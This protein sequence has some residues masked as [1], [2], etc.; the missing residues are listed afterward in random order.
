MQ[1]FGNV[2]LLS[3]FGLAAI[4]LG[5][6]TAN[7]ANYPLEI[8]NIKP[9]GTGGMSADS[10]IY[11]AYP[12]L[13]Y[14]I[15]AAA[16]GGA[17]PYTYSLTGAPAGMTINAQTGE[18]NWASPTGTAN[19][20]LAVV[21][22]EGTRVTAAWSIATS[23]SG[24]KFVDAVNGRT[25]AQNGCSSSCGTGDI[26]SPWRT[27]SDVYRSPSSVG[28]VIYFKSGTYR[29]LD[30][31][32]DDIN[33]AWE[34]VDF[35][36]ATTS[37]MWVAYPGQAPIIDLAYNPSGE[38][39]PFIRLSA[40]NAYIDGFEVVNSHVMAFQHPSG[41]P[42]PTF[43]RNR[44]HHQNSGGGDLNGSNAAAI[45]TTRGDTS[46]TVIQ[47]NE[48]WDSSED[49]IKVYM[50]RKLLIE[51]NVFRDQAKGIEL[52]DS[53]QQFTVRGNTFSNISLMAIGGNMAMDSYT[54]TGEMLFNNVRSP[55]ALD[56]NQNGMAGQIFIYRNTFVGRTQVR[57]TGS[58]NGPF[59]FR[60]NVIVSDDSGTPS[61]SHI[62]HSAV[63]A[64][65]VIT[66]LNNL[67]GF[68]N[69]NI[70]DATG[71][72]TSAYASYRPTHGHGTM[73]PTPPPAGAPT[74]PSGVRIISG[75]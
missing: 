18:I 51:N 54:T 57:N 60:N 35:R 72:L 32:R 7:A 6:Q 26:A 22:S 30:L 73:S 44:F 74:A 11:H 64:P 75:N 17:Y 12:G 10:R 69:N 15:R 68:P 43:R 47:D 3:A 27:L 46:F 31:P 1:V 52:K 37:C 63:S 62:Y 25:S 2:K 23:T 39:A 33:G 8:T 41:S 20:T 4:L 71:A 53:I 49:A 65:Q 24:F 21:D 67:V 55:L 70:V 50:Q 13:V 9:S 29:V 45:M 19:P 36:S 14:N 5:G 34:R 38:N 28:Q 48:F 66:I 56:L 61:G 59:S 42:G 58:G 40:T 16:V